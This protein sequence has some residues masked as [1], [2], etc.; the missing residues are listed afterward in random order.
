MKILDVQFF[1]QVIADTQKN[2]QSKFD[3]IAGIQKVIDAFVNMEDDFKGKAGNAIRGY[4]R[5]CHQPFLLYLQTF[6]ADYNEALDQIRKDLSAFEPDPNGYIDETF[7][8]GSLSPALKKLENTIGA[9]LE[10][11]NAAIRKVSDLVD[12]K[13]IDIDEKLHP[14]V[15]ARKRVNKTVEDLYDFDNKAV[16]TLEKLEHNL[17]AMN[18]FVQQ[19]DT[20]F[21]SVDTTTYSPNKFTVTKAYRSLEGEL[22]EKAGVKP[23][24]IVKG[25]DFNGHL[26]VKFHFYEDGTVIMAFRKPGSSQVFYERVDSI[27]KAAIPKEK[28]DDPL[29][30]EIWNGFYKGA[31]EV[32]GDLIETVAGLPKLAYTIG[33]KGAEF[34]DHL[35]SSP[36]PKTYLY[37]TV[38][39]G[40]DM[41]KYMR[42]A[43]EL[44]FERDFIH[45]NAETRTEFLTHGIGTIGLSLLGDKGISKIG[46]AVKGGRLAE[47]AGKLRVNTAGMPALQAA[48]AGPGKIPY[49]VWDE[50]GARLQKTTR[51]NWNDSKRQDKFVNVN[52]KKI[53]SSA[54]VPKKGGETV[55]GH[56]LQKHSGRRPDIWGEIKGGP[57]QINQTALKHLQEILEGPG[58]FMEVKNPRGIKFLEKKLPDGRGVRLNLD[59]TFKGFI[60]Q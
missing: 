9:I 23:A 1:E 31:G 22:I 32:V 19:M 4:F 58:E 48:G 8:T 39:K 16:N 10:D 17:D 46:T 36:S 7:L 15:K 25:Q 59:G 21:N 2:L 26:S 55:A 28:P 57:N 5:D 49:N 52:N 37:S 45:G 41:A 12:I 50:L 34:A 13:T 51:E 29:L 24:R 42:Q 44:A 60:D 54:T 47:K 27:P 43:V 6:L 33:Y 30:L 11:A 3:Q 56:A 20:M 38:H 14:I 53:I 18:K 35:L 40:I